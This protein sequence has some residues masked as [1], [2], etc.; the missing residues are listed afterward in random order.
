MS[1]VLKVG[2]ALM[3][4]WSAFAVAVELTPSATNYAANPA[5]LALV[6]ELV[7]EEGFDRTEL[8]TLFAQVESKESILTA[9]S[10]P[11]EKTKPWYEYRK[12]FV[13]DKRER[14][15]VE[16]F[17]KHKQTFLRAEQEFGVP[18]EII[19]S[20]MGVET[21]YGRITGSYRVM[22]A[23]STLAFDYPKRSAFFTKEL[24]SY[25]IL[26][27][28]QG[29]DPLDI[30]GSYAGAM[31]YGQ[32]MPSSY[33]AYAIDFD[34]DGKV[35]IWNNPVDAIGSV[36]NYFKEHDWKPGEAVVVAANAVGMVPEELFNDRLKPNKTLDDYAQAGV[37]VAQPHQPPLDPNAPATAIKFELEQGHEYWLGLH[38]FYVITRYNHSSMYAMSV[39][40]LSQLLALH[41]VK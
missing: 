33:R 35:D 18:V 40:Q 13:T 36:A 8:I 5:T 22:D 24:K 16:F 14:E 10:R 32:F 17:A 12:I 4:I 41:I 21:Y 3:G 19:L 28:E 25:L 27:R 15:G 29:V 38:N 11:A 30:K 23:L 6:E 2:L 39:Y 31:G 1:I 20:I 9:M 34:D 37:S 26:S 7:Q